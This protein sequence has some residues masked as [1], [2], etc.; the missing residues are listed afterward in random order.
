M[1][2]TNLPD[3]SSTFLS[4]CIMY[5]WGFKKEGRDDDEM[6]GVRCSEM[7]DFIIL[8]DVHGMFHV[9]M[10]VCLYYRYYNIMYS[11]SVYE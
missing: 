10:Y 6:R 5:V 8:Q 3:R 7:Y 2:I 4:S 9:C 1:M 11:E